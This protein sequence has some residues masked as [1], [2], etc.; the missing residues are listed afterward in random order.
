MR[1]EAEGAY[2]DQQIDWIFWWDEEGK[3]Q[4]LMYVPCRCGGS[5]DARHD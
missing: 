1:V 5:V 2:E 3:M 4:P